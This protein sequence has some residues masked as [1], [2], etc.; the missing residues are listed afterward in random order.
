MA[1]PVTDQPLPTEN[2]EEVAQTPE[3][4]PKKKTSKSYYW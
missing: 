1:N 3:G 2:V 4:S